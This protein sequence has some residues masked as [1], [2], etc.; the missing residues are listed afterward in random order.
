MLD[1]LEDGE[2]VIA[3][4][5]YKGENHRIITLRGE[6]ENVVRARHETVNKRFK[7][8]VSLDRVFRHNIRRHADV[9]RAVAVI[10]QLGIE[11]GMPLFSVSYVDSLN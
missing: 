4:Q 3:D 6:D 8:F 11:N 7:Q 10:T 9:F 1:V 5:G 2:K